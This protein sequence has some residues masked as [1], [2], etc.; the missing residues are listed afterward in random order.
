MNVR[1]AFVSLSTFL[2]IAAHAA[3]PVSEAQVWTE[4]YPV[5]AA[6]PRLVIS[7]IWGS[8]RVRSGG[9]GQIT[10]TVD[11]RRAAPNR[12]LFDRSLETIYLDVNA[13]ADGV[14]MIVAQ[15]MQQWRRLDRCRGCRVDYQF[16]VAV[17]PGTLIDVSTVTD[18]RIDVDG[19]AGPVSASNV[20]GPIAVSALHDCAT[21]ESVNGTV[22]LTFARTP[23]RDCSIETI[24]GDIN[25]GL[26][27]GAGLDVALDM[28]NGRVTSE[29]D[30]DSVALPARVEESRQDG[31]Y[32]Y[33]IE[34]AAGI[35]LGGGGPTFSFTSL[36]GDIRITR[37]Q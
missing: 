27:S 31:R 37:N 25:M 28:F 22:D 12:A 7:N 9:S 17:P 16:E 19:I 5:S 13:N 23:G 30:V 21:V 20:N 8:V 35:R 3:E 29:F 2:A 6:T 18:G 4:S 34:Q 11:E 14:S 33:R 10:V 26:P 36:N 15:P 1:I 24:N 32:R